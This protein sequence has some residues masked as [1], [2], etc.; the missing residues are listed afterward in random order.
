[1]NRNNQIRENRELNYY[2][3]ASGII[4][5][6]E[7]KYVQVRKPEKSIRLIRFIKKILAVRLIRKKTEFK[8]S[9][10][11]NNNSSYKQYVQT[12]KKVAISLFFCFIFFAFLCSHTR[13]P[14][15]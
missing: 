11:E 15:Y 4:N 6:G 7:N 5:W 13:I 8:S 10:V 9:N 12:N 3:I 2:F 1:M 14:I